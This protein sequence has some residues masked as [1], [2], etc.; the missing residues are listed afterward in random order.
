M[1]PAERRQQRRVYVDDAPAVRLEEH[2]GNDAHV[3]GQA[4]E[5]HS[6]SIHPADYLP[7]EISLAGIIPRREDKTLHA[8]CGGLADHRCGRLVTDHQ[9]HFGVEPAVF[10]GIVD[11]LEV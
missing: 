1:S 3:S 2:V 4:D 10:A 9:D 11:G 8:T 5:I 6:Q 7:L